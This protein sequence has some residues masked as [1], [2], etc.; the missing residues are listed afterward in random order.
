MFSFTH[1]YSLRMAEIFL[2]VGS[3][4]TLTDTAHSITLSCHPRALAY[5]SLGFAIPQIEIDA[6]PTMSISSVCSMERSLHMH[7]LDPGRRGPD[8]ERIEYYIHLTFKASKGF[9]LRG[10]CLRSRLM[11]CPRNESDV[12]IG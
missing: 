8:A 7:P 9:P 10:S 4:K 3:K 2:I 11:R 6:S 5:D 1:P 12:F